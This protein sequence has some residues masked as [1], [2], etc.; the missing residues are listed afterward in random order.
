MNYGH[1]PTVDGHYDW[2]QVD[3]NFATLKV[4]GI[5]CLR[6]AYN[7]FNNPDTNAL[8]LRAKAQGIA[9]I[10]GG[11]WGVLS[12]S[13]LPTYDAGA[14]AEAKWA[15]QNGISQLGLG[16][17]QESRLSGITQD[18][19]AKHVADLA[20]QVHAVY[21]G[22]VSYEI[23]SDFL[24]LW[25]KNGLGGLDLLGLNVYCG[26]GCNADRISS[27]IQSFGVSHVYVSETNSDMDTGRFD[28]DQAHATEIQQDYLVLLKKFPIP[29]YYF[30]F[31]SGGTAPAHW[32]LYNGT[33]LVQPLTAAALGIK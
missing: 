9:P 6:L 12:P 11:D 1:Q 15:E 25:Q 21:K 4:S 5:N 8:A 23:N 7:G 20:V 2:T 27:A 3:S 19:W 17:E 13:Q 18:E 28:S 29:M 16:N 30:N 33:T 31:L 14:I 26:A 10:V 24:P 32:G 22:K